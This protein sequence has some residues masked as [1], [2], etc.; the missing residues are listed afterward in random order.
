MEI[1]NAFLS[2][3]REETMPLHKEVEGSVISRAIISPELTRDEYV[4]YLNKVL[5]IHSDVESTVFPVIGKMITDIEA[6]K[7][8]PFIT[9]DLLKLTDTNTLTESRFLDE[10][11]KSDLAFNMGLMY[12]TEGSTLG[13]QFILKNIRGAL[14]SHAPAGFLNVYGEKTGSM[15]KAFMAALQDY[16]AGPGN[17]AQEQ[18]IAGA[19]YGFERVKHIFN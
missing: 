3:L 1:K 7:K 6:R 11:Y 12:V 16:E 17:E 2:R 15:W 9:G 18:I 4:I 13:G 14:G 5:A 19:R 8:A 10:N